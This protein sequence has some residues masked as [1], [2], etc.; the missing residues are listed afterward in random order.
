MKK[1]FCILCNNE[2]LSD[3]GRGIKYKTLKCNK[4]GQIFYLGDSKSKIIIKNGIKY[5]NLNQ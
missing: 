3:K 2:L 4:C 1:R 5:Y